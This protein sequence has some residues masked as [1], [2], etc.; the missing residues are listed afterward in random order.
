MA[1]MVNPTLNKMDTD[2]FKKIVSSWDLDKNLDDVLQFLQH[3]ETNYPIH[4]IDG[5]DYM[6]AGPE[7]DAKE[8]IYYGRKGYH[9]AKVYLTTCSNVACYDKNE[10]VKKE[11]YAKFKKFCWNELEKMEFA[12]SINIVFSR[13]ASVIFEFYDY[14]AGAA[15]KNNDTQSLVKAF[16][17]I[18]KNIDYLESIEMWEP[19]YLKDANFINVFERLVNDTL[20]EKDSPER[21][22]IRNDKMFRAFTD[23]ISYSYDNEPCLIIGETGSGKERISELLHGFSQRRKNN[24]R[25]VNCGGFN[26]NLFSSEIQ[27]FIKGAF[28]GAVSS[29]L[30]VFLSAC[31]RVDNGVP[32]GYMVENDK[33]KFKIKN[34]TASDWPGLEEL[35][36]VGG[37]VFLDEINSLDIY[38]QAALL[39]IIDKQEV[40]VLGED[41]S[42]TIDVKIICATN[43][44]PSTLIQEGLF[45]EDLY[46]RIAKGIIYVPPL[47]DMKESFEEIVESF[48]LRVTKKL[49]IEKRIVIKPKAM[50]K[51]KQYNWPGNMRE[52]ENVVYRTVKRMVANGDTI[53]KHSHIEELIGSSQ[54]QSD[55]HKRGYSGV[56]Y[57][58]LRKEY[59]SYF[60]SITDGNQSKAEELT[61]ISRA[62]IGRDWEKYGLH[63]PRKRR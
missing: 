5:M 31:G 40:Q 47:R 9:I 35:S 50:T 6:H 54:V 25:V 56:K 51:L 11:Y 20:I 15:F 7:V 22:I 26:E 32:Y 4:G 14:L 3:L 27:G 46:H 10:K 21:I 44:L 2:W 53:I 34:K 29:R 39:R 59:L 30:G 48:T 45:R 36:E 23:A 18:L 17:S 33:I 19:T 28:T 1:R 37:T 12:L 63:Q 61:G 41:R 16:N 8:P 57:Q 43:A 58:E 52:L 24:Y 60:H 49:N 42:R 38:L 62:T 55:T 13:I